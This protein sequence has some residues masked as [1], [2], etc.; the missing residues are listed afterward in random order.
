[1]SGRNSDRQVEILEQF[2][3]DLDECND[4]D[5]P[6][7]QEVKCSVRSLMERV[8]RRRIE[9]VADLARQGKALKAH[10]L[11]QHHFPDVTLSTVQDVLQLVYLDADHLK[12]AIEFVAKCEPR[13]LFS[14]FKAL[15]GIVNFMKHTDKMRC[16]C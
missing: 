3:R 1:M 6:D 7:V 14:A 2:L 13:Q 5:A 15:I 4:G 12:S 16:C 10:Q 11:M 8:T 9:T